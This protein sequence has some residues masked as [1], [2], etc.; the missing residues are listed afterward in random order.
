MRTNKRTNCNNVNKIGKIYW[1]IFFSGND[2]LYWFMFSNENSIM[3]STHQWEACSHLTPHTLNKQN[4]FQLINLENTCY[5]LNFHSKIHIRML[6]SIEEKNIIAI[7]LT[8]GVM[9]LKM[10]RRK[11]CWPII[12]PGRNFSLSIKWLWPKI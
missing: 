8:N 4:V 6:T 12:D 5:Q 7:Q 9:L 1:S 3:Y 10:K 2:I 11:M